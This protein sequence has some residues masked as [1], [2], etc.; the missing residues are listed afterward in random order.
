MIVSSL[1]SHREANM[2]LVCWLPLADGTLT[3]NGAGNLTITESNTTNTTNGRI[4]RCRT[5]NG[6]TSYIALA[7]TDLYNCFKG[8]TQPFS[9]CM[10][11]YNGDGN[12]TANSNRA[13]YF[14]DYNLTGYINFNIEKTAAGLARFYWAGTPDW[15]APDTTLTA[16]AW[17]H[18]VFTYDGSSVKCY[19]NGV[20]K[21]TRSGALAAKS[22]TTGNFQ[23]GRDS[24][25]G[26]TAFNGRMNDFRVYDHCLSIHEIRNL[27]KA[28]LLHYSLDFEEKVTFPTTTPTY[29]T[30]TFTEKLYDGSGLSVANMYNIA[31][32]TDTIIGTASAKFNGTSAYIE[33]IIPGWLPEYTFMCWAKFD[34]TGTYHLMDCRNSGNSQGMQPMYCGLGYGIQFYSINGGSLQLSAAT[35]GWSTSDTNKWFHITGVVTTTGCKIYVNGVLKASNTAAKTNTAWGELPFRVGTRLNGQYWFNGKV[36][37][38]KVF[39]SA[40]T[41]DEIMSEYNRKAAIDRNGALHTHM[42]VTLGTMNPKLPTKTSIVK[43]AEIDEIA[44]SNVKAATDIVKAS[45]FYED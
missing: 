33:K 3:N 27:N 24:R 14:G 22:K 4:G 15:N 42:Y 1:S 19:V 18:L 34:A 17:N 43:I 13:V 28:L 44:G 35:C 30:G 23:L 29:P 31:I 16:S 40:L 20:L 8:G 11:I 26:D 38:V 10:W 32:N 39:G 9:I 6:S 37:D 21:A 12:G 2:S 25:T 41:A 5:F 36:A 7:G 45:N